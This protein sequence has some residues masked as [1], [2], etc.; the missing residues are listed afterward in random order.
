MAR[1]DCVLDTRPMAQEIQSVSGHIKG[2]TAA[3]VSMKAAVI[4][5]EQEAADH[6]CDNVNKGF[7]ALI[8][9]QISQKIAKLQSEVDSHVMRLNQLRKQLLSVKTRMEKDYGMITFR[10]S[11]LF[12]G[13]N[14]N[15]QQRVF[16][17]DKPTIQF[18]VRDINAISNR[19]KLLASVAPITQVE[20]L[21]MSQKIIASNV[22]HRGMR[23]IASMSNFLG[24][25][26]EQ[27]ELTDRVMLGAS[28]AEADTPYLLPV[29]LSESNYDKYGNTRTEVFMSKA[30]LGQVSQ[31]AVK[32]SMSARAEELNWV[33]EPINSEVKSEFNKMLSVSDSSDRVKDTI[34]KLFLSNDYQTIKR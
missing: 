32:N 11:K 12:N 9:S 5:A 2:T 29:I 22:K 24:N 6:V 18:A 3:V 21:A 19:P 13:L 8:H 34:N 30:C 31:N 26:K 20:S 33:A 14:K 1:I 23:V 4:L 15:L 16:E 17:L 10:Y 7:Y 25:M 27:K 28:R